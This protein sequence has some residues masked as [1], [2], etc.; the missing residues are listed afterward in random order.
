MAKEAFS[1]IF[2]FALGSPSLASSGQASARSLKAEVSSLR[3]AEAVLFHA[4]WIPLRVPK[5][6]QRASIFDVAPTALGFLVAWY[7]AFTRP[8]PRKRR[9]V[10][11]PR[12]RAG[13][14]SRRA[15]GAGSGERPA[16]PCERDGLCMCEWRE[17]SG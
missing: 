6:N 4:A 2:R 11:G 15:C 10:R 7:L 1:A 17:N 8:S 16:P 12:V 5:F 9:A 3:T 13:L 14:T